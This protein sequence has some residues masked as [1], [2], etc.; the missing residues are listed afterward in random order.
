MVTFTSVF[1]KTINLLDRVLPKKFT[2]DLKKGFNQNYYKLHSYSSLNEYVLK[3]TGKTTDK[4]NRGW[5]GSWTTEKTISKIVDYLK[6]KDALGTK[7]ICHGVR[8]GFEVNWFNN[9]IGRNDVIGTDIDSTAAKA[10]NII[11]WDFQEEN[12]NYHLF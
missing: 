1:S 5:V 8:T 12:N 10:F 2:L 6:E 9:A 11:Q 3:Q 7:G 4:L